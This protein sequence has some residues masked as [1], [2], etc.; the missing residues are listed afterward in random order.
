MNTRDFVALTL[1]EAGGEICGKTKLQKLLYF[2]GVL[3]DCLDELGYRAHFYGPYILTTL[4]T[5]WS[6]SRRSGPWI[7]T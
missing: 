2:V 1:R 5:L 7:R 3:T 6:N 4:P